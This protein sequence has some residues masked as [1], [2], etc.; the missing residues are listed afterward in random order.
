MG[1]SAPCTAF[2]NMNCTG[3]RLELP[4]ARTSLKTSLSEA[5]AMIGWSP[6]SCPLLTCRKPF[7][8]HHRP[9]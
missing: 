7:Q 2:E 6:H 8:V 3:T 5:A 1:P 9:L 4:V